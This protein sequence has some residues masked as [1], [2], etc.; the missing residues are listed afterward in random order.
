MLAQEEVERLLEKRETPGCRTVDLRIP[1]ALPPVDPQ[2]Q[3]PD[4]LPDLEVVLVDE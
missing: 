2:M 1:T 3:V 4:E